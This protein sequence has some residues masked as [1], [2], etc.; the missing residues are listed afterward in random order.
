MTPGPCNHYHWTSSRVPQMVAHKLTQPVA[1]L[2][3]AAAGEKRT[4]AQI[5]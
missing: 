3:A 4:A 1:V 5:D 2:K